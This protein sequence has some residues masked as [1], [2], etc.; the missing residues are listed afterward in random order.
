[1]LKLNQLL[2]TLIGF[3]QVTVE[4]QQQ[5]YLTLILFLPFFF[6]DGIL[7]VLVLARFSFLKLHLLF[8]PRPSK[9]STLYGYHMWRMAWRMQ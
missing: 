3:I 5:P 4:G 6:V 9:P 2:T 1:M 7:I 8:F